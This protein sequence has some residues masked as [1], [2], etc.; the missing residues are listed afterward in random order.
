MILV[1][2]LWFL[3]FESN[4]TLNRFSIRMVVLRGD[5]YGKLQDREG[6]DPLVQLF[7]SHC[8]QSLP[9][10]SQRRFCKLGIVLEEELSSFVEGYKYMLASP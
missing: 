8:P 1:L 7:P 10:I 6:N 2:F 5:K 9:C 4:L 3:L